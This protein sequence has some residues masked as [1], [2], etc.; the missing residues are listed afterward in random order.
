MLE[1]V[2]G[3]ALATPRAGQRT[4]LLAW[5]PERVRWRTDGA[6]KL[7]TGLPAFPKWHLTVDGE[8]VEPEPSEGFL[9]AR[10]PDTGPH[11]VEATFQRTWADRLGVAITVLVVAG[12]FALPALRRRRRRSSVRMAGR[13]NDDGEHDDG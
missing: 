8:A 6:Q 10:L 5:S 12:R 4:D 11:T 2:G 3:V 9:A 13:L 1:H 7:V